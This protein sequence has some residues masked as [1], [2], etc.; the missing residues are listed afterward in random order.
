MIVNQSDLDN[1][2]DFAT[3][4]LAKTGA[5]LSLD[6]LVR[7]WC[8]EREHAETVESIERGVA[9]AREG[10]LHELSDVDAKIRAE[11]GFPPRRQ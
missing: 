10:R 1:F 11:L 9:D 7:K 3:H 4:L 6:E 5:Y 2:H 8:A